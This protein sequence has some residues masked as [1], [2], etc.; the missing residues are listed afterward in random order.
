MARGRRSLRPS[1]SLRISDQV[2][3]GCADPCFG[4]D[5]RRHRSA[6]ADLREPASHRSVQPA[7]SF[8]ALPTASRAAHARRRTGVAL[9]LTWRLGAFRTTRELQRQPRTD[10][11][12]HEVTRP[13]AACC[14]PFRCS[15][16]A[17]ACA[18]GAL[19]GCTR[20]RALRRRVQMTMPIKRKD[21]V[22]TLASWAV[23][24]TVCELLGVVQRHLEVGRRWPWVPWVSVD[25][26]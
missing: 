3:A 17:F 25:L 20:H 23:G 18:S 7:Y 26:C 1:D 21:G 4:A 9:C 5:T 16:L 12:G 10:D 13:R 2:P 8:Q 24:R 22:P 14:S 11:F 19:S 6:G 15:A